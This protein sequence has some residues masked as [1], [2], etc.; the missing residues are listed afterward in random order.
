[1]SRKPVDKGEDGVTVT[2]ALLCRFTAEQ[3]WVIRL[4][5]ERE[6]ESRAAQVRHLVTLGIAAIKSEGRLP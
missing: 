1:M 5:A 2:E 3:M 6:R 4:L